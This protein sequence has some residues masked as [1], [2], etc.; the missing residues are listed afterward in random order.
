[1]LS[2]EEM[3]KFKKIHH[4]LEKNIGKIEEK[5][6][7][8]IVTLSEQL[9][10]LIDNIESTQERERG[11]WN[12]DISTKIKIAKKG[13][14]LSKKL[15]Y[16][17]AAVAKEFENGNISQDIG[18]KFMSITNL[19][20]TNKMPLAKQEFSYFWDIVEL[21][22]K[23]ESSKEEMKKKHHELVKNQNRIKKLLAELL[24]LEEQTVDLEKAH[25]YEELLK[26][27]EKLE[28]IRIAFLSSLASK[29]V[30]ELLENPDC[31]MSC[32]TVF[33][34]EEEIANL[35]NFFSEHP[36][37]GKYKAS[38]I[39]EMF[40][41]SEKKISHICSDPSQFKKIILGNREWFE[42]LNGLAK[43]DIL[44]VNDADDKVMDFYAENMEGADGI[45]AK[46]KLLRKEKVSCREQ[47]EKKEEIEE[48]RKELSKYSKNNLEAELRET[49]SLIE[50][51]HSAPEE[52]K[53]KPDLFSK[54]TSFFRSE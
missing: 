27:L 53:E 11:L 35:R 15:N 24:W 33:P 16:F 49:D 1:M 19:I 5:Q 6:C 17:E 40:D 43:T 37:L 14:R 44:S 2:K 25:A 4:S 29:P 26:N 28:K 3:S 8:A 10:E 46:I 51:L 32:F 48:K 31:M 22:R 36:E 30:D 21:S 39:C 13:F 42:T 38:Q 18:K 23:Y 12:P 47:Y 45:V 7:F 34:S 50:L 9:K 20:K 41:F 52:E 54:L